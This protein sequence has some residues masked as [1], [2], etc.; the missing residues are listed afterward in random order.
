MKVKL[1]TISILLD[2][3][4]IEEKVW[5]PEFSTLPS[6]MSDSI[7][8][9]KTWLRNTSDGDYYFFLKE[10]GSVYLVKKDSVIIDCQ[11]GYDKPTTLKKGRKVK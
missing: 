5:I 2:K 6:N 4:V 3:K 1:G 10:N 9:V 7:N 11:L 8:D